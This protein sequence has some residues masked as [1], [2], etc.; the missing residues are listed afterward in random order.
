MPKYDLTAIVNTK[1]T[2]EM[3][4]DGNMSIAKMVSI[5]EN[6]PGTKI[7]VDLDGYIRAVT[8]H[9]LCAELL[10]KTRKENKELETVI[11]KLL[12]GNNGETYAQKTIRV[13]ALAMDDSLSK[14]FELRKQLRNQKKNA[15]PR[16]TL[17]DDAITTLEDFKPEPEHF[18]T[19]MKKDD[20]L[21]DQKQQQLQGRFLIES[22]IWAKN[23]DKIASMNLKENAL[24][25][26]KQD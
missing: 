8:N 15:R 6:H 14:L 12:S 17:L 13:I 10:T 21:I 20:V 11:I 9:R 1:K 19:A 25:D 26:D 16:L 2:K 22:I 4:T 24:D 18:W 5:K 3:E 23:S 7:F